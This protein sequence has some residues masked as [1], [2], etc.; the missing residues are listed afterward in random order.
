MGYHLLWPQRLNNVVHF[1]AYL[2]SKGYSY[3]MTR[4]YVAA[5]SFKCKMQNCDD[6]F[7][8]FKAARMKEKIKEGLCFTTSYYRAIVI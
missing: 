4:S 6:V 8:Y 1:V 3:S 5:I 2:A 7:Y